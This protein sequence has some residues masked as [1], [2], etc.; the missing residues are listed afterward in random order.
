MNATLSGSNHP[1]IKLFSAF[2]VLS[3]F[4]P[5]NAE[6]TLISALSSKFVA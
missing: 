3:P 2:I 6:I 1:S 4:S 5:M